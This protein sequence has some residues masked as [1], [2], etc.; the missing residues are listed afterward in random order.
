MEP[1]GTTVQKKL[2]NLFHFQY[3]SGFGSHF[4]SEDAR[5]PGALPEGQNSPQKCAYGLYA[6]QLSGSAFTAP[7][8]ENVRSWLYRIR[9]SV[10]HEPFKPYQVAPFLRGN[11][12]DEQ[13]PNPNQMRWSPFDLPETVEERDFVAGLHTVCGAGDVRSRHGLAVH[14]YLC[15]KSMENTAFYNS[16]GDFLIGKKKV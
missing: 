6:E 8:T 4:S 2:A 1:Y 5:C 13:P 7:R 9:P 12:W 11:K 14:V 16:D 10:V 3:L 15:N